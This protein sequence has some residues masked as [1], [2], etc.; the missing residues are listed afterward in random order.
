MA[1]DD[2]RVVVLRLLVGAVP[3]RVPEAVI[4]RDCVRNDRRLTKRAWT[5]IGVELQAH[6]ARRIES[7][8]PTA[9]KK[10]TR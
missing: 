3:G 10:D 9:R 6:D 7:T 5:A 2:E 1:A 8:T 4:A